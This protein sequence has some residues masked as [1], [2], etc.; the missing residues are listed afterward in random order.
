MRSTQVLREPLGWPSTTARNWVFAFA[1]RACADLNTAALVLIGSIARPVEQCTDVDLLYVY[2][3]EPL[4]LGDHPLDVDIRQY[5]ARD[6]AERAARAQDVISWSLRFGR[7]VCERDRFWTELTSSWLGRLS[8]PSPDVAEERANRAERLYQQLLLIG[9]TE[10][11]LEQHITL[12]THLAW[13]RLLRAGVHPASRP[14]LVRQ[15]SSIGEKE[16]AGHLE[17]ALQ[18]RAREVREGVLQQITR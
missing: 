2:T 8:L 18:A 16:L 12:L 10:A 6:V 4:W 3:N 7:L 11:A 14:E 1:K 13:A 17:H 15:L 5:R 9:D